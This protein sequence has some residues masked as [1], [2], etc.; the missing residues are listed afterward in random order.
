MALLRERLNA[1]SGVEAP[2]FTW[3]LPLE[4]GYGLPSTSSSALLNE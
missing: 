1:I 4:G 3:C 2:A